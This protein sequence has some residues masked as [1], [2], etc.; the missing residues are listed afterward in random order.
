MFTCATSHLRNT[1]THAAL[2]HRHDVVVGVVARQSL[3]L[4]KRADHHLHARTVRR[5]RVSI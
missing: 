5:R 2:T 3:H 1:P 4:A